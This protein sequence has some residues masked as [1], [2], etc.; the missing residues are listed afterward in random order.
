MVTLIKEGNVIELTLEL[1]RMEYKF[2][3]FKALDLPQLI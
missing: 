3:F 2:G 1:D